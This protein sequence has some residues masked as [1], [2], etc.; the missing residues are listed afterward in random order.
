M[1]P[2]CYGITPNFCEYILLKSVKVHA[3]SWRAS[4]NSRHQ[5]VLAEV[6]EDDNMS[7]GIKVQSLKKW[8][9]S[10]ERKTDC[11]NTDLGMSF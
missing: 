9:R 5:G 10:R 2:P 11:I 4:G 1:F 6:I 7:A 8:A 3:G